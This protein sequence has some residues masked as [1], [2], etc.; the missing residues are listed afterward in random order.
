M[1][2]KIRDILKVQANNLDGVV[3]SLVD[4]LNALA[5]RQEQLRE[6]LR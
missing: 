5:E 1:L 6:L 4:E 2:A 3:S